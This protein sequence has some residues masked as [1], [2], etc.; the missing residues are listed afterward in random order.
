MQ[1]CDIFILFFQWR[2]SLKVLDLSWMRNLSRTKIDNGLKSC[3][4]DRKPAFVQLTDVYLCGTLVS[5]R[6]L[7]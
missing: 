1:G 4:S 5:W 2:S 3:F 7:S 6:G